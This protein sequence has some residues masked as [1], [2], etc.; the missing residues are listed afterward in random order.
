MDNDIALVENALK[1]NTDSFSLLVRKYQDKLFNFLLK[2]NISAD[3]AEEIS[4]EVFIKVYNNLYKYNSRW[5][6]STWLYK[7]AVN[8]LRSQYK[9]KKKARLTD[10]YADIQDIACTSP[11]YPDVSYE[12]KEQTREIVRLI[13]SLNE[14]QKLAFTLR[15]IQDFSFKEIGDIMGISPEAAKMKIQRAK[16][17]LCKKFEKLQ[18]ESD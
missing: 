9:K 18:K 5:C 1:G 8:T 7:I 13:D 14:D 10:Y 12:I 16:Q 17:S 11:V 2:M 3:D 15:Y 4:Q 6:F